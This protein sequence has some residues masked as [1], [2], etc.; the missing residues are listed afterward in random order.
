MDHHHQL[1]EPAGCRMSV[2]FLVQVGGSVDQPPHI[3]RNV[4]CVDVFVSISMHLTH[5]PPTVSHADQTVSTTGLLPASWLQ[6]HPPPPK[7]KTI[8]WTFGF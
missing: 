3:D 8:I 4:R 7:S 6:P 2:G 1:V 5:F